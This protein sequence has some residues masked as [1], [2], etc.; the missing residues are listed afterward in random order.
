MS[1]DGERVNSDTFCDTVKYALEQTVGRNPTGEPFRLF[2]PY[3]FRKYFR[4]TTRKLG[5]DTAEFLMGHVVGIES[6]SAIYS[7]LRDLD[8][9]A[10]EELRQEYT[11]LLP[12]L[13]TEL[14]EETVTSE[15][16]T[17]REEKEALEERVQML[18][19]LS[20]DSKSLIEYM[21]QEGLIPPSFT[22]ETPP[23]EQQK[24]IPESELEEYLNHGWLY[25]NSLNNGS[26]KCII[27]R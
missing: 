10:I 6:L 4:R 19:N 20:R 14:S 5:E 12:E 27:K 8:P 23:S 25:V 11:N 15:I 2:R 1:D 17:L 16:K 22:M 13:E 24:V 21:Q 26:G 3:G 18:E 7:G 9:K